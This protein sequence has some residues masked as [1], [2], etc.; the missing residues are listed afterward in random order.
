MRTASLI[1]L[2]GECER[3]GGGVD[4]LFSLRVRFADVRVHA[5]KC[6]V[7]VFTTAQ[8]LQAGWGKVVVL[9]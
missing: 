5:T 7:F 6:T 3:C 1:G 9:P 4:G 2:R 8:I